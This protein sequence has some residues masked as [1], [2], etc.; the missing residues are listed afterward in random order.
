MCPGC[1]H[2]EGSVVGVN[3]CNRVDTPFHEVA[4]APPIPSAATN[5][6]QGNWIKE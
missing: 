2:G 3:A 4:G 6:A 1:Y 5:A